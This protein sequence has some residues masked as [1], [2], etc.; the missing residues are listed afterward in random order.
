MSIGTNLLPKRPPRLSIVD[1]SI[2]AN[3]TGTTT[4]I[5]TSCTSG[6]QC[7]ARLIIQAYNGCFEQRIF[8]VHLVNDGKW[9]NIC[10]SPIEQF[11]FLNFFHCFIKTIS[12][13]FIK[14]IIAWRHA[15]FHIIKLN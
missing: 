8:L 1:R 9:A 6:V 11:F 12:D 10:L 3:F 15:P 7:I 14:T 2:I 13:C 5:V 4:S